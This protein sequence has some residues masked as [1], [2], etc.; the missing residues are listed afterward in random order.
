MRV[1]IKKIDHNHSGHKTLVETLHTPNWIER[2]IFRMKPRTE[3]FLGHR[4]AW[5]W[6]PSM[7]PITNKTDL[8]ELEA[9]ERKGVYIVER[10][11]NR[12]MHEERQKRDKARAER[13]RRN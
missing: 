12:N 1:E 3:R 7:K 4:M 5:T 9:I 10:T 13:K 11:G 6:F 2:V 8:Q